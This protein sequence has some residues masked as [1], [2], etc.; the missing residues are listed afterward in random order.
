MKSSA[1]P[2]LQGRKK[3]ELMCRHSVGKGFQRSSS[4]QD[5]CDTLSPSSEIV[6]GSVP[7]RTPRSDPQCPQPL[8]FLIFP[9][10]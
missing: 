6:S 1:R 7:W 5:F 3:G 9:C 10:P 2:P 8:S 4:S